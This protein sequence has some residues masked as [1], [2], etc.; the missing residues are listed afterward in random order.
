MSN[1]FS[2]SDIKVR[3]WRSY[4]CVNTFISFHQ[5]LLR[6]TLFLFR[7]SANIMPSRT[8]FSSNNFI[9]FKFK[10]RIRMSKEL[11]HH[12]SSSFS[13]KH[14]MLLYAWLLFPTQLFGSSLLKLILLMIP[15]KPHFTFIPI[16]YLGQSGTSV[17]SKYYF[18]YGLISRV[19]SVLGS[20]NTK[21]FSDGSSKLTFKWQERF[22][23]S[24][25]SVELSL[26]S[27]I[28]IK[29]ML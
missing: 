11:S 3:S 13:C 5:L 29:I 21:K 2:N 1:K 25:Y 9:I 4:S 7:K 14:R 27:G 18:Q 24:A 19:S 17:T 26:D 8:L 28:Y 22:L 6:T 23:F 20:P 15:K 16:P 12:T 10:V